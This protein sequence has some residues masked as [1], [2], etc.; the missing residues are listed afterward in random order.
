M[1]EHVLSNVEFRRSNNAELLEFSVGGS[2]GG[3]SFRGGNGGGA[4]SSLGGRIGAFGACLCCDDSLSEL[5]RL[6]LD[7]GGRGGGSWLG[8][9]LPGDGGVGIPLGLPPDNDKLD[10]ALIMPM[11]LGLKPKWVSCCVGKCP[12]DSS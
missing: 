2:R 9:M 4:M 10:R 1:L 8:G 3:M 12:G 5:S 7:L 6:L 11:V